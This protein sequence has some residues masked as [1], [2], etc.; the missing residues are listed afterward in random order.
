MTRAALLALLGAAL[1]LVSGSALVLQ[2]LRWVTQDRRE[3]KRRR[4]A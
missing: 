4:A 3:R 1:V 2:V